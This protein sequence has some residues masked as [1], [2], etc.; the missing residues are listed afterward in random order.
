MAETLRLVFISHGQQ[1]LFSN[2]GQSCPAQ[3]VKSGA[4]A[5]QSATLSPKLYPGPVAVRRSAYD[6][7]A[8]GVFCA[9]A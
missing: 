6:N 5:V 9:P 7:S 2:F 4:E 8:A 3:S 1:F